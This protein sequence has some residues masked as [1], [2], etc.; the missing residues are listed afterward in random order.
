MK[1]IVI[2]IFLLLTT[3]LMGC[4]TADKPVDNEEAY[5]YLITNIDN[6][7]AITAYLDKGVLKGDDIDAEIMGGDTVLMIA[8]RY[9]TNIDV[10]N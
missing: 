1:K 3:L 5:Q 10:L 4:A 7:A 2:V 6:S 9:T 8:A